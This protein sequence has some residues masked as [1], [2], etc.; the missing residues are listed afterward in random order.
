MMEKWPEHFFYRLRKV[1]ILGPSILV[2]IVET[3]SIGTFYRLCD[4]LFL[5]IDTEEAL[6][7]RDGEL[8]KQIGETPTPTQGKR[9]AQSIKII[10]NE[11][12]GK[13][14]D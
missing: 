7:E 13:K 3:F 2:K 1:Y 12:Y 4:D 14:L 8:L 11:L 6:L 5:N 10:E 9:F